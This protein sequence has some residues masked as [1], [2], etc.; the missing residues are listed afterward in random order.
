[1]YTLQ[2]AI[3]GC[4]PGKLPEVLQMLSTDGVNNGPVNIFIIMHSDI[5]ETNGLF[6]VTG[7][8]VINDIEFGEC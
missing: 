5:S 8:A 1:M 4:F 7:R 2:L 3:P 6:H